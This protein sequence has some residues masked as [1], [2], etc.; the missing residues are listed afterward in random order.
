[1][2][3][4]MPPTG[5]HFRINISKFMLRAALR[6]FA[7]SDRSEVES[8]DIPEGAVRQRERAMHVLLGETHDPGYLHARADLPCSLS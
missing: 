5:A 1:M 4:P 2:K 6:Y 8:V 7:D 3:S